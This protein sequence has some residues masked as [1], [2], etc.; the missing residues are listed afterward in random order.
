[1]ATQPAVKTASTRQEKTT[2]APRG[3][4]PKSRIFDYSRYRLQLSNPDDF[5][6][7]VRDYPDPSGL[8]A[9]IYRG[10]P[11]IDFGLISQKEHTIR[12][13]ANV[14]EMMPQWI[15]ENFG[16]GKYQVKLNDT[17]RDKGQTEVCTINYTIDDPERPPIYDVRTLCLGAPENIDEINRLLEQ[18]VLLRDPAGVPRLRTER[19]GPARPD[20]P[21]AAPAGSGDLVSR[22]VMGQVLLKLITQGTQNPKDM[23]EQSI[24]IAKLLAPQTP[25]LS[26]DQIAEMVASRL[27]ATVGRAQD[28]DPF[29][30]WERMEA[31][32]AKARGPIAVTGGAAAGSGNEMLGGFTELL[33]A[34]AQVI[35][36]IIRGVDYL[37]KQRAGLQIT[38]ERRPPVRAQSPGAPG[39]PLEGDEMNLVARI[40]EVAEL[41][42]VK[43]SEGMNGFDF[44]AYVCNW[45]PGGLEVFRFLEPKGAVGVLGLLSMN[46]QAAPILNDPEKRPQLEK[47]L[48]E[49]FS[50]DPDGVSADEDSPPS[51]VAS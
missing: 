17:N 50:Y 35:P 49:F 24:S 38:V 40:T 51:A 23:M 18:G 29:T 8:L 3:R 25:Q 34:A 6:L 21:A 39:A 19:D 4:A 32:I 7:Y 42:F 9:Y 16:R 2:P 20:P 11:K 46:P 33:K 10:K 44:A 5:A 22:D 15:T 26:V 43:I 31:F 45:H 1:M 14:E 28:Q 48:D 13:T 27:G 41:A 36:E 12:K 47:F 30:A 37:Q